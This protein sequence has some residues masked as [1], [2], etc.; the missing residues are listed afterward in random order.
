MLNGYMNDEYIMTGS[1][2]VPT[3]ISQ[4]QMQRT[5][6]APYTPYDYPECTGS[7]CGDNTNVVPSD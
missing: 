1:G 2:L 6:D 7:W 4:M 3:G 5:T